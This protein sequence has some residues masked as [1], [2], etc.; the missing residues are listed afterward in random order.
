MRFIH[1]GYKTFENKYWNEINNQTTHFKPSGG[2]WACP[3]KARYNWID[4]CENNEFRLDKYRRDNYFTFE[5]NSD[6]KIFTMQNR[7]DSQ[8]LPVINSQDRILSVDWEAIAKEV[9]VLYLT[10]IGYFKLKYFINSAGMGW[11]CESILILNKNAI[12][13]ESIKSAPLTNSLIT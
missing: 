2:L 12:C 4:W 8:S 11:D 7:K 6:A 9:D 13:M 3:V 5:L 10:E 1:Y